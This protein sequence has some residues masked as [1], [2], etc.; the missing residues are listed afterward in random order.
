MYVYLLTAGVIYDNYNSKRRFESANGR[1]AQ[2]TKKSK[3]I[4]YVQA[5]RAVFAS[6]MYSNDLKRSM[7]YAKCTIYVYGH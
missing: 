6:P 4:Y 7:A 3:E 2:E 5:H 1:Q